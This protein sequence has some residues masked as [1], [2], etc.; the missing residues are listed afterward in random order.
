MY[1]DYAVSRDLFHWETQSTT[2]VQSKTGQRYL[3]QRDTNANIALRVRASKKDPNGQ[4]AAYTFLGLAD[5]VAY[6][7]AIA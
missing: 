1:N 5:F 3:T 6:R 2:S 4:T 7:A